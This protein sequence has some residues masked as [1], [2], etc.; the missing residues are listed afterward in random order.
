[1]GTPELT[2]DNLFKYVVPMLDY[3]DIK[4][5]KSEVLSNP[6]GEFVQHYASV[7]LNDRHGIGVADTPKDALMLAV[8]KVVGE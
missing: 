2:L 5:H 1:M 8:S 6:K 3:Y 4:S 7:A